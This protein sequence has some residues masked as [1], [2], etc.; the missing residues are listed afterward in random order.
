MEPTE[1]GKT[2]NAGYQMGVRYTYP[3]SLHQAWNFM[4]SAKG[5][6]VWLGHDSQPIWSRERAFKTKKGTE[7]N[8][9]VFN[10]LSHVRMLYKMKKWEQPTTLQLRFIPSKTGTTLSF[11]QEKLTDAAQREEMLAHWHKVAE[12]LKTH[13]IPLHGSY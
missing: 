5:A 8:V 9:K 4:F 12:K 6:A 10:E 7:I 13:L 11:H 3:V 1:T 2:K